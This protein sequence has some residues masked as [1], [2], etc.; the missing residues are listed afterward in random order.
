MKQARERFGPHLDGRQW[1]IAAVATR[2][3]ANLDFEGAHAY[4]STAIPTD[5][6]HNAV[7]TFGKYSVKFP[8]DLLRAFLNIGQTS[9]ATIACPDENTFYTH[10]QRSHYCFTVSEEQGLAYLDSIKKDMLI[11]RAGNFVYQIESENCAKWAHEK[12]E[13][14]VGAHRIPNVFQMPLS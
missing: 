13:A 6:G 2:Q 11:A 7:Y 10:R 5:R 3:Y 1:S 9:E 12:I 8:Q 14:V 4:S